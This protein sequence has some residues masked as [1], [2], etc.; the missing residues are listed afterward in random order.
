MTSQVKAVLTYRASN[1]T[2]AAHSDASFLSESKSRSRVGSH[3]F[4]SENDHIPRT[5]GPVLSIAGVIKT[6]MASVAEAELAA[7]FTTAQE[8]V[9]LRNTL[10]EIERGR[11]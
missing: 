6:F 8:M 4:I 5:N 2:L 1:M 9:P 7:L 10:E 3:I 11:C